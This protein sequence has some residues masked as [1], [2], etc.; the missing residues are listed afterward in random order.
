ME[1]LRIN[2]VMSFN[3]DKRIRGGSNKL[4]VINIK[5]LRRS[6]FKKVEQYTVM[7]VTRRKWL[8]S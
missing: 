6:L 4:K 2:I 3:R 8:Y 7:D 1:K 5:K